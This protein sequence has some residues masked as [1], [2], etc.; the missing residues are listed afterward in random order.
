MKTIF[1]KNI[2]FLFQLLLR[3][4]L[5]AVDF[6]NEEKARTTINNWV[7]QKTLKKIQNLVTISLKLVECLELNPRI[8]STNLKNEPINQNYF[9][10]DTVK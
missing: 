5:E 3:N 10:F 6:K 4:E 8:K 1:P 2:N 7:E 9:A